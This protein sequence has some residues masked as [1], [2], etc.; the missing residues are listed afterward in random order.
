VP[1][2]LGTQARELLATP[3]RFV[4]LVPTARSLAD[5]LEVLRLAVSLDRGPRAQRR[6]IVFAAGEAGRATRLLGPLL[7]SPVALRGLGDRAGGPG[8]PVHGG[9]ADLDDRSHCAAGRSGCVAVLATRSPPR[10]RRALHAA[11]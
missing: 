5:L 10:C 6:A 3:A 1:A 8:R 9:R 4:K 2:D 7:A 11:A